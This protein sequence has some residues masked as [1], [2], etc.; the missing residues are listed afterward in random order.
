MSIKTI[1][2]LAALGVALSGCATVVKG[3]TQ[4]IAVTTPPV[5]GA[6]CVLTSKEGTWTVV[7]PGVAKVGK[8]KQDIQIHCTKSGYQDATATIPSNFEGWTLGNVILGG[9]IGFGVDAATGAMNE[10]PH[11]FAVP[12]TPST[13]SMLT[14]PNAPIPGTG[15]SS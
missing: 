4:S 11:A 6:S 2:A 8:T 5:E 9:L 3:T 14:L 7:T 13:S 1:A 15:A 12:M 10:Y